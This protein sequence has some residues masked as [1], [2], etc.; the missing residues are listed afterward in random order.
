M[1]IAGIW[2]ASCDPVT[3]GRG[4]RLDEP[5]EALPPFLAQV[6]WWTG[7]ELLNNEAPPFYARC[8]VDTSDNWTIQNRQLNALGSSSNH[9]QSRTVSYEQS[10]TELNRVLILQIIILWRK[11]T[12]KR[13][14]FSTKMKRWANYMS[15]MIISRWEEAGKML[16]KFL[17]IWKNTK[18]ITNREIYQQ[19]L[20]RVC[21]LISILLLFLSDR[22]TKQS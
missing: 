14:I 20:Q 3:I 12:Y 19:Y 21:Q 11:L 6:N 10:W 15:L 2:D 8:V 4:D 5:F 22:S 18:T 13:I 17:T 7:D 1:A 16:Y 9:R